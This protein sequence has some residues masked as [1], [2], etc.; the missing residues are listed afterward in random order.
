LGNVGAVDISRGAPV[1]AATRRGERA[2]AAGVL[3]EAFA[4]DP[5]FVAAEPDPA[6]RSGLLSRVC[7]QLVE[8]AADCGTA[9]VALDAAGTVQAVALWRPA[10]AAGANDRQVRLEVPQ[11]HERPGLRLL[12]RHEQ[13]LAGPLAMHAAGAAYLE[14]LAV[15]PA[16][17]G[18]GLARA[19]VDAVSEAAHRRRLTRVLLKTEQPQNVALYHHLGFTDVGHVA[20]PPALTDSWL[21]VRP[22]AT[23]PTGAAR[24]DR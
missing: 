15:A 18:T 13:T 12:G 17:R 24:D 6:V 5:L 7:R 16:A 8:H 11:S 20:A 23:D 14:L 3:A 4:A 21:L 10:I 19:L 9:L 2:A 1:T 22:V